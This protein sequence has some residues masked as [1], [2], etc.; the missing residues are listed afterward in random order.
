MSRT[1][2]KICGITRLADALAAQA[3][4]CDAIGMV[5]WPESPRFVTIN[6]ATEIINC[7]SPMTT[8]VG[9]F[10]GP[11]TDDVGD[12][13][14]RTGLRAA[15]LC[16]ALPPGPW[17][18]IARMI[19]LIRVINVGDRSPTQGD[20]MNG[21]LDYLFDSSDRQVPGGTGRTFDW[22][23]LKKSAPFPRVWL[24]GGLNATNVGGAIRA[25]RPFAVDVS[26]GV[27]QSPGVK[28][29]EKIEAFVRAVREADESIRT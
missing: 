13:S 24:A 22:S 5:F 2:I 7:L 26:S 14:D 3:A 28:S 25:V 1:R 12:V 23:L 29:P 6:Q 10:V 4:G 8:T 27:E 15:Q 19:H 11:T 9:V 17:S 18:T 16:S 21:V 20:Q